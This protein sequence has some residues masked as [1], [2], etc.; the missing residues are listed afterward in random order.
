LTIS[1]TVYGVI[2]TINCVFKVTILCWLVKH[3]VEIVLY[4]SI[5]GRHVVLT[6]FKCT[7]AG[8]QINCNMSDIVCSQCPR[9][10][11]AWET[12]SV[13]QITPTW[14]WL[15]HIKVWTVWE[16][17]WGNQKSYVDGQTPLRWPKHNTKRRM[18]DKILH[19]KLKTDQNEP[20]L[21]TRVNSCAPTAS[22]VFVL[23]SVLLD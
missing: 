19:R 10:Y 16:V 20:P 2:S 12:I 3:C 11:D 6:N 14:N 8:N 4:I 7:I 21:K 9:E 1:L 13:I 22:A 18:V 23:S 17:Q 15:Y 5:S